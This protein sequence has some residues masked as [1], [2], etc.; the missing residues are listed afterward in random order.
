[1]SC[2]NSNKKKKKQVIRIQ[3]NMAKNITNTKMCIEKMKVE[4][5]FIE[6]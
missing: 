1:M 2:K 4:N 5:A 3:A 6:I